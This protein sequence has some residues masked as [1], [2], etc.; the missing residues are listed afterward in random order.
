MILKRVRMEEWFELEK[1]YSRK[2]TCF[3]LRNTGIGEAACQCRIKELAETMSILFKTLKR[4]KDNP[5]AQRYKRSLNEMLSPLL[6]Q[7][8]FAHKRALPQWKSV[9][10]NSCGQDFPSCDS[11]WL[12]GQSNNLLSDRRSPASVRTVPAAAR[13]VIFSWRINTEAATVM[14]GT[15]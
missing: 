6:M 1:I 7:L 15:M 4:Y 3:E 5:E 2:E 14:T 10:E 9:K 11:H 12:N 13:A 8:L